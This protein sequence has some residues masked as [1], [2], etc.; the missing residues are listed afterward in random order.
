MRS[1]A[2]IIDDLNFNRFE[3][4][5]LYR[6]LRDGEVTAGRIFVQENS[7][8]PPDDIDALIDHYSKKFRGT[9]LRFVEIQA[10]EVVTY[11]LG[12]YCDMLDSGTDAHH[13]L[14]RVGSELFKS[15]AVYSTG[16]RPTPASFR[17]RSDSF[18]IDKVDQIWRLVPKDQ[19]EFMTPPAGLR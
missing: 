10:T 13:Y 15:V 14:V 5:E 17:N 2:Q 4:E 11:E 3:N 16:S 1:I 7:K 6:M 9:P 12:A 18:P 8:L 19:K